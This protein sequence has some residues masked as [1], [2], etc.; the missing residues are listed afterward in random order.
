MSTIMTP[1]TT[2]SACRNI[3]AG[4]MSGPFGS[5]VP[6]TGAAGA[7]GGGASVGRDGGRAV[8]TR[9]PPSS[10]GTADAACPG[11]WALAGSATGPPSKTA[12]TR[13]LRSG[14]ATPG[15]RIGWSAGIHAGIVFRP[16]EIVTVPLACAARR[17]I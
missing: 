1:C 3:P 15:R 9:A 17:G 12:S 4:V 11:S 16:P 5:G 14:R 10:A 6:A 8:E 7:A 13:A 2:G